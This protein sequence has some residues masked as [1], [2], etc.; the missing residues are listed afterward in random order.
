MVST[1]SE[2]GLI[3]GRHPLRDFDIVDQRRQLPGAVG[4]L[5]RLQA[6]GRRTYVY[7]T[8]GL[9]R[10]PLTVLGF[11]TLV[12]GWGPEDAI[13]RIQAGRPGAVPA[14]EA[15]HGCVEDLTECH[16]GA[17]ERRAYQFYESGRYG[18]ADADWEHALAEVLR[19]E[20]LSI[21][22]TGICGPDRAP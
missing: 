6:S 18:S 9:G 1:A 2:L 4:L 7:C 15:Y 13:Q 8:A 20:L 3:F 22:P 17:I 5:A 21:S 12:E 11:L 14:W 16:R 19:A 10:A